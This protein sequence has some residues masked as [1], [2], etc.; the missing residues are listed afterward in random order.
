MRQGFVYFLHCGGG[1]RGYVKIGFSANPQAR[2][3]AFIVCGASIRHPR[4]IDWTTMELLGLLPGTMRDERRLHLEFKAL[5]VSGEWFNYTPG[6]Q[7]AIFS[8]LDYVK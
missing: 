4:D 6:L 5:R 8:M 1:D 3:K 7:G 2:F